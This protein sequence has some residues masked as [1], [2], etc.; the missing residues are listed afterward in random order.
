MKALATTDPARLLDAAVASF[1]GWLPLYERLEGARMERF[2]GVTRWTTPV[3]LP[4]FNGVLT[5]G[6]VPVS[7]A[8]VDDLLDPFDAADRPLVWV[9]LDDRGSLATILAARGFEVERWPAMAMQLADLPPLELPAGAEIR[10][11]DA[12]EAA[13]RTA[14][15]ISMTTNGFPPE[16]VDPM[17]V[18]AARLPERE[19]LANFLL[20]ADGEPVAAS[21]LLVDAGVAGLFNVGTL[22][23]HRRRGYGRAVSVAAMRAGRD[24]GLHVGVLQASPMG[25]SVYR[26]IGFEIYGHLLLAARG[27]ADTS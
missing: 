1:A 13:L 2:A 23:G 5:D 6:R 20:Y 22:A 10:R 21:S 3:P 24:A 9:D 11:V 12:D 27:G 14:M 7:E 16:S 8:W 26:A 18:G 17:F 25:E 15:T 4:I 19:R